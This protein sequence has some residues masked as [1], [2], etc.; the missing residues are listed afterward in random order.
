MKSDKLQDAV[1]LVRDDFI[2]DAEFT[3][4][5]KAKVYPWVKWA[6]VAAC[7]LIAVLIAVP[8]L[9]GKAPEVDP[10]LAKPTPIEEPAVEPVNEAT[11][12]PEIEPEIKPETEPTPSDTAQPGWA[13]GG[14]WVET[15]DYASYEEFAADIYD[16]VFEAF[17]ASDEGQKHNYTYQVNSTPNTS[18]GEDGELHEDGTSIRISCSWSNSFEVVLANDIETVTVY[19][20]NYE[21]ILAQSFAVSDEEGTSKNYQVDDIEVQKI[22]GDGTQRITMDGVWRFFEGGDDFSSQTI[23]RVNI[24]GLWYYVEGTNE[25]EVD[26]IATEL[27]RI[28]AML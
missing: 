17:A 28:A 12:E 14:I 3:A 6:A 16:P 27:A 18:V 19:S 23:E 22:G 11:D 24:N 21:P 7:V 10:K 15:R 26:A 2:E 8:A 25:A 5:R 1:G 9:Q 20:Y 13:A 4:E